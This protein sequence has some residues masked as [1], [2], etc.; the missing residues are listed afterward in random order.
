MNSMFQMKICRTFLIYGQYKDCVIVRT[1]SVRRFIQAATI[2]VLSKNK[3]NTVYP[4]ELHF[5]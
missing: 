5:S 2:Y 3:K 1:A 4:C